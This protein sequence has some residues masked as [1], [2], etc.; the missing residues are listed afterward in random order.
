MTVKELYELSNNNPKSMMVRL[1][2]TDNQEILINETNY[3]PLNISLSERLYC[4]VNNLK[5]IPK[6]PVCGNTKRFRKFNKG[7]FAT[8]GNQSCKSKLMGDA[9][10]PDRKDYTKIQ[11]K[12]RETYAAAHNGIQHN[13]QDPEFKKQ[14]FDNYRKSHNGEL[15]GVCSE[16]ARQNREKTIQENYNGD[17]YA[18]L[19]QG[20]LAKYSSVM[21]E[22]ELTWDIRYANQKKRKLFKL[23]KRIE[24]LG[25]TYVSHDNYNVTLQ[26]NRCS[27]QFTITRGYINKFFKSNNTTFCPFC[28]IKHV[29]FRSNFEKEIGEYIKEF[30]DGEMLFNRQILGTECDILLPDK[31]IAIEAN[32]MYWHNEQYKHKD[33]HFEKKKLVNNRG[34]ILIQIWEDQWQFN[35]DAVK[36]LLEYYIVGSNTR[37][38]YND[39]IFKQ[40][41]QQEIKNFIASNSLEQYC[42]SKKHYGIFYNNELIFTASIKSIKGAIYITNIAQNYKYSI[43]HNRLF[44]DIMSNNNINGIYMFASNDIPTNKLIEDNC[45]V[46]QEYIPNLFYYENTQRVQHGKFKIYD[47]GKSLYQYTIK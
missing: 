15:C 39:C 24:E 3:L 34:Y 37:V 10:K 16:K 38:N 46:V 42:A 40:I 13:M 28:D 20:L 35:K 12:M 32:G 5:E 2:K 33:Y 23:T 27:K 22:L 17:L 11:Q 18:M 6:C 8:C 7:Y 43:T 30:Y 29:S 36:Q 31:K 26:C 21:E 1:R 44:N 14:F 4:W 19:K 25:Y 45:T 47:S 41:S 9:N